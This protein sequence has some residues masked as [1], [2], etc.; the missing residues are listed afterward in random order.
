MCERDA[1]RSTVIFLR[2]WLVS[3]RGLSYYVRAR[4]VWLVT[5]TR[6]KDACVAVLA[7][8]R[9]ERRKDSTFFRSD[10]IWRPVNRS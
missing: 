10:G 5:L 3:A 7:K 6:E 2:R 8:M 4:E 1:L 9:R